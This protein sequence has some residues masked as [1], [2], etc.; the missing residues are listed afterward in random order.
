MPEPRVVV[1]TNIWVS[2]LFFAGATVAERESF[3]SGL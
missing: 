1:D 2:Y 3:S